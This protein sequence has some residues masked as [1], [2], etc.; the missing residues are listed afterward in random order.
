MHNL[1]NCR[2]RVITELYSYS[3]IQPP[4]PIIL[5]PVPYLV[6]SLP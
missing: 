1:N 4:M 6:M 5:I 2:A 3:V